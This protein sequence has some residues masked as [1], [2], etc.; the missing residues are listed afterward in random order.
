MTENAKMKIKSFDQEA[1]T[2]NGKSMK[3]FS[4]GIESSEFVVDLE[5]KSLVVQTKKLSKKS[6]FEISSP[7]G[8]AGIR[9]TEFKMGFQRRHRVGT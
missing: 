8:T 2:S 5:V 9:G 3:D 4:G 6:N 1:F 7:V